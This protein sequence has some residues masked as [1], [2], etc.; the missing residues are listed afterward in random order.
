MFSFKGFLDVNTEKKNI[1]KKL[2]ACNNNSM[3]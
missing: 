3:R 1:Y 2:Q